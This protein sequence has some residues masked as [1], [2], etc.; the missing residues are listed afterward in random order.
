MENVHLHN[1]S[2]TSKRTPFSVRSGSA[3]K[4]A[5]IVNRAQSFNSTNA[6]QHL[7]NPASVAGSIYSVVAGDRHASLSTSVRF[8]NGVGWCVQ[9]SE[10]KFSMLFRQSIWLV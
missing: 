6:A 4:A 3:S 8:L 1:A 2:Q 7:K 9:T 5:S 10:K